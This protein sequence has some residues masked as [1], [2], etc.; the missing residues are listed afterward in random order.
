LVVRVAGLPTGVLN[1]L[2]FD[3]SFAHVWKVVQLR[4]QLG[5]E[6]KAIAEE[7]FGAIGNLPDG[8]TK[9]ALVG[10]RRSL[11]KGRM[12]SRGEWNEQVAAIPPAG[13][14]E[15]ISSW[16]LQLGTCERFESVLPEMLAVEEL[17]IRSNL[18]KVV[19]D[20]GFQRALSLSSSPLFEELKKWLTD[21][22]RALRRKSLTRLV[23]YVA[24]A[25]AKTSPYSTFTISGLADWSDSVFPV[26]LNG[27]DSVRGVLELNGVFL[28]DLVWSLC[29]DPVLARRLP[30]R[31]NPSATL[32]DDRIVFVGPPPRESLVTV[33][34][35]PAVLAC[36]RLL[37]S[38]ALG[39][40][41]LCDRIAGN[42]ANRMTVECFLDRLVDIGLLERQIPVADQAEDPLGE[43][44]V[45][46]APHS[47]QSAL[48]D[49]PEL[50]ERVRAQLHADVPVGDVPAH[51]ERQQALRT[52]L[53]A[54]ADRVEPIRGFLDRPG[55]SPF[56]ENAVF[57]A[58]AG[59]C[60]RSHW[61]PALRDL[62]T[63]RHWLGAFDPVL[64]LKLALGTYC[65]ERFGHGSQVPL[66]EVHRAIQE[67]LACDPSVEQSAAA[68]AMVTILRASAVMPFAELAAS[69]LPRLRELNRIQREARAA[70]L[71]AVD[72]DGTI[73]VEPQAL[74]YLL[75]T[76]PDW[77]SSPP[78]LSFFVQVCENKPLNLV[79]N[80]TGTGYGRGSSRIDYLI[81]QAGGA[82]KPGRFVSRGPDGA[83]L[84]ELGGVFGFAPNRRTPSVPHEIDYPR[85]VSN[86]PARER[87]PV[88][89]LMVVHD[90]D[91]DM[92]RLVSSRL[93][94]EVKALH[95]GMM[96][97]F[98]LPHAARML[99]GVF[100][101]P[102]HTH[103]NVPLL[104]DA[105]DLKVPDAIAA[106]PRTYMG[107]VV[108][109]R[110]RWVVPTG[111]VPV[112]G[113]GEGD[114]AYWLRLVT[115]LEE[116]RIPHRSF[117]RMPP[118]ESLDDGGI[119][120]W[121]FDKSRKPVYLDVASWHLVS[122]FERMLA[123]AGPAVIFEEALPDPADSGSG[124]SE[125]RVSE[126]LVT[127][128]GPGVG[129]G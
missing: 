46:M 3:D 20:P 86:R 25:A 64:P 9:A 102:F 72:D 7:L 38:N 54:L 85:T 89:D 94:R 31:V 109:Q 111:D 14:A 2:R 13:T 33:P 55:L 63:V 57:T 113:R 12:P 106:F 126:F 10:L 6:G 5:D 35:T 8:P 120:A 28:R 62:D 78:S 90:P 77:I 40:A 11:H 101:A 29:S 83:V 19:Q 108:V 117:V 112:R 60:S 115:W 99:S 128:S 96:A 119:A 75:E 68:R 87:L 61:A 88:G 51:R 50:I 59:E 103:P 32:R 100:G 37:E 65:G 110:A 21:E 23:K 56:H 58:P 82:G 67:E 98:L 22:N 127:I 92:V 41:E 44:A 24:R 36:L 66:L 104:A 79:L 116:R 114:A 47:Q 74:D 73:R 84:A 18:R 26:R 81:R 27:Q 4:K 49:L 69:E 39:W 121:R 93:G 70:L 80:V 122:V 95:L 125:H 71:G 105:D 129:H 118:K 45:W 107:R 17:K 34:A 91:S 52:A 42:A 43:L 97:D 123:A 15:R 124:R 16:I 30:L 1:Q 48:E 53:G 76:R